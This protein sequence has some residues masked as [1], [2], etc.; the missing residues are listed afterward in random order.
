MSILLYW[1]PQLYVHSLVLYHGYIYH[2]LYFIFLSTCVEATCWSGREQ[3]HDVKSKV[4]PRQTWLR[5]HPEYTSAWVF[6][7]QHCSFWWGETTVLFR[8]GQVHSWSGWI[9]RK[10]VL[11]HKCWLLRWYSCVRRESEDWHV[12]VLVQMIFWVVCSW[13]VYIRILIAYDDTI[14]SILSI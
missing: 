2:S 14:Y 10:L 7:G 8:I 3:R 12:G 1:N 4:S 5:G 6:I 11:G 13:V 9:W